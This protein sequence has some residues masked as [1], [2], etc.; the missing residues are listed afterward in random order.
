VLPTLLDECR[1]LELVQFLLPN[2]LMIVRDM[3]QPDFEKKVV[4][5]MSQV[6]VIVLF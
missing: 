6:F 3:S 2:I 5:K 4:P 1:D